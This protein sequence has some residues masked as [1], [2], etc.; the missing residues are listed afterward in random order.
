MRAEKGVK[1]AIDPIERTDMGGRTMSSGIC[2]ARTTN[3]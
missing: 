3:P 2:P 1:I